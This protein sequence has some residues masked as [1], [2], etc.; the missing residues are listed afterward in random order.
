MYNYD[1]FEPDYEKQKQ[2]N[3]LTVRGKS[4]FIIVFLCAVIAVLSVLLVLSSCA[5]RSDTNGISKDGNTYDAIINVNNVTATGGTQS[6]T[7]E[8]LSSTEMYQKIVP[9]VV[10]IVSYLSDGYSSGTG[11]VLSVKP[12]QGISLI[13]TNSHV[14]SGATKLSVTLSDGTTTLD[15]E[16]VGDDPYT[17]LAVISV[18]S[19]ALVAANYGISA[20]LNVGDFVSAVGNPGGLNFSASYGYVSALNR[21]IETLDGWTVTC[22]QTDAAINPGNSGGPLI[23]RYGNVIGINSSKIVADGYEGLGFAINIDTALEIAEQLMKHGYV[24]GRATLGITDSKFGYFQVSIRETYYVMQILGISSV[25][26]SELKAYDIIYKLDGNAFTS[27][28]EY[29]AFFKNKKPGDK[30]TLS[31]LRASSHGS[32]WGTTYTSTDITVTL[33]EYQGN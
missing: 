32:W 6:G 12:E 5:D 10:S 2:G 29:A 11:V 24:P 21:E 28:T 18:K 7:V 22:I 30:V 31:V 33:Q 13:L 15:A 26:P 19:G 3:E 8:S 25:T 20:N 17:D 1:P 4:A 14:I 23:D 16:V 27:S 9:S